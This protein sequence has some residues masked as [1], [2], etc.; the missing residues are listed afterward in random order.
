MYAPHQLRLAL[1]ARS[2][3]R[4]RSSS[5]QSRVPRCSGHLQEAGDRST[6]HSGHRQCTRCEIRFGHKGQAVGLPTLLRPTVIALPHG[7]SIQRCL[8]EEK[9]VGFP[10]NIG[11]APNELRLSKGVVWNTC[12]SRNLVQDRFEQLPAN[13]IYF[14]SAHRRPERSHAVFGKTC[15]AWLR[16][17]TRTVVQA[18]VCA[19]SSA[20]PQQ[21]NL[22]VGRQQQSLATQC[23]RKM[24]TSVA[25][26]LLTVSSQLQKLSVFQPI[27]AHVLLVARQPETKLDSAT[28]LNPCDAVQPKFRAVEGPGIP[29]YSSAPL[30]LDQ[31]VQNMVFPV[32]LRAEG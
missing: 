20:A 22:T 23:I 18:A 29:G 24:C 32:M 2:A 28:A 9:H 31:C 27:R 12:F 26:R 8:H 19:N 17:P 5:A 6:R 15:T 13:N 7:C 21:D 4:G 25:M 14:L 1:H 3:P 11:H 16:V 30:L 10:S